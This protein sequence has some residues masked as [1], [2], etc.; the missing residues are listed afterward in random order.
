MDEQQRAELAVEVREARNQRGWS[1]K[2]LA[3]EAGVS[4]NT[5]M[6]LEKGQRGTQPA[7]VR[8]ILDAL[9][10]APAMSVIELDGVPEDVRIFLTVAAQRLSI[11]DP[12]D[13]NR[14]LADVYPRLLVGS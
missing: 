8:Q 7:K 2:K 9:G 12:D 11:M 4:E 3:T 13:R 10:V 1:Q 14:V 5:V 6:W